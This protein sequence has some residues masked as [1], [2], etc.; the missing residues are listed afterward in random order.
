MPAHRMDRW[1]TCGSHRDV[2]ERRQLR[3]SGGCASRAAG[4]ASCRRSAATREQEQR[5]LGA[6]ALRRGRPVVLEHPATSSWAPLV[7]HSA[8]VVSSGH[9]PR[10]RSPAGRGRPDR[11]R[12]G[13][14]AA[15]DDGVASACST[16]SG[17]CPPHPL[18][19]HRPLQQKLRRDRCPRARQAVDPSI[20]TEARATG[21]CGSWIR[22][23]LGSSIRFAPRRFAG[24]A[25]G[26]T[27]A[28]Q[29]GLAMMESPASNRGITDEQARAENNPRTM[30][31]LGMRETRDRCLA[32]ALRITGPRARR[33][34]AV[35]IASSGCTTRPRR[36]K[37]GATGRFESTCASGGA[38][39][40]SVDDHRSRRSVARDRPCW[41]REFPDF[42]LGRSR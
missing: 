20:S 21:A 35:T 42:R 18:R 5:Q 13:L 16:I 31:L 17:S 37:P 34:R 3:R 41:R 22:R 32:A 26:S 40:R 33:T 12:R 23:T 36:S 2:T 15:A 11:H 1:C 14:A 25:R 7:A 10:R 28:R 19:R 39:H 29:R 30:G 8:W 24:T 38:R 6:H 9:A 27:S 4:S